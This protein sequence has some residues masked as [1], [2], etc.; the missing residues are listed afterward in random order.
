MRMRHLLI[1]TLS[2]LLAAGTFACGGG[3]KDPINPHNP[4]D[5]GGA[6][7]IGRI[8]DR[9]GDPVGLPFCEVK[10]TDSSGSV[11]TPAQQPKATGPD[12]G[13]FQFLGL[14]TG[15]PLTLEISLLQVS[16]GRNLGWIQ[17]LNLTS[18]GTVDLGDIT[19]INDFLQLGWNNYVSKDYSGAILNFNRS[20]EDRFVQT[21][22][23]ESSSAYTGLGWVHAKRGKDSHTGLMYV[24]PDTNEWMDTI[25]SYEWDDAITEFKTATSNLNDA[26]AWTGMGGTYLTLVGQANKD[27][28]IIGPYIPFYAF[29]HYYFTESSNALDKA[30]QVAPNYNCAH[31]EISA[32][33]I[34]ATLLF[35]RWMEGTTV[36]EQDI[37]NMNLSSDINQGSKQL[38]DAMVDLVQYNPFPQL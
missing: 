19:L 5:S 31:D 14:P 36:T 35:L 27:P 32:N 33:D 26:D 10:L 20:M 7:L 13:K 15:I 12:A 17:H 25:N 34:R 1:L 18:S 8:L 2:I 29:L 28:Y 37:A 4:D 9:E 24:D 11:I 6:T 21:S 22:L 30:L 16:M 38:L 23:T 3:S